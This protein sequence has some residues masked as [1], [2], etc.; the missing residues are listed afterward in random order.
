MDEKWIRDLD[1][2]CELENFLDERAETY[3]LPERLLFK[4]L[5]GVDE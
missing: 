5:M 2:R 3:P 4:H 1:L